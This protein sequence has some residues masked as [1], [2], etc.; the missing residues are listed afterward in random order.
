MYHPSIH[1]SI[2][3]YTY[4]YIHAYTYIYIH[5]HTYTYQYIHTYTYIYIHIY[6]SNGADGMHAA[7]VAWS[8]PQP[9]SISGDFAPKYNHRCKITSS[10]KNF[11]FADDCIFIRNELRDACGI[12][13]LWVGDVV[14]VDATFNHLRRN[15]V[16]SSVSLVQ[17]NNTGFNMMQ[18]A[19]LKMQEELLQTAG[20]SVPSQ[21]PSTAHATVGSAVAGTESDP[22]VVSAPDAGCNASAGAS[23]AGSGSAVMVHEGQEQEGAGG[24]A[25]EGRGAGG[26]GA[27]AA[28]A[29]E[30][31]VKEGSADGVGGVAA[32]AG[33]AAGG[34]EGV[35]GGGDGESGGE[36]QVAAATAADVVANLVR[37]NPTLAAL[38]GT[39]GS[40]D[41]SSVLRDPNVLQMLISGMPDTSLSR[42]LLLGYRPLFLCACV[43]FDTLCVPH[44]SPSAGEGAKASPT[45]RRRPRPGRRGQRWRAGEGEGEAGFRA[46][47]RG[48]RPQP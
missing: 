44:R 30:E 4:I 14:S 13:G 43:S 33:V 48:K 11:S 28:V 2:H 22:G 47:R 23:E 6:H 21:A 24:G 19:I 25:G 18:D 35:G 29:V 40:Q 41:L 36:T 17:R 12:K 27:G 42:S 16:A 5:I 10:G 45:G 31:A 26:E 20:L 39:A 37:G 7:P 3:T 15:W 8:R 1:P 32:G 9:K 46:A 38:T 34:E